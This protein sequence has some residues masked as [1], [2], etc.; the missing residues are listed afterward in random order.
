VKPYIKKLL[1]CGACLIP[2]SFVVVF[3][4]PINNKTPISCVGS[5]GV[6]PFVEQTASKYAKENKKIDVTV[7]AGGSG[8]GIEE[9]SKGFAKIGN[10]SKNPFP[11]VKGDEKSPGFRTE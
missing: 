2:I 7:E 10:A 1:I 9:I 3:S 8:F 4:I 6:K 5:S 11:S